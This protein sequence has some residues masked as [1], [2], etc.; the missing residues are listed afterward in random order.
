LK[1]ELDQFTKRA[2]TLIEPPFPSK[3]V[4]QQY[5]VEYIKVH[6][7]E[8]KQHMQNKFLYEEWENKITRLALNFKLQAEEAKHLND[9]DFATW[10]EEAIKLNPCP[11]DPPPEMNLNLDYS[12]NVDLYKRLSI[13]IFSYY[14][15]E[16]RII[17]QANQN[18]VDS[19][20]KS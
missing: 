13:H 5:S 8:Y 3:P 2:R 14:Q 15:W 12:K 18:K 9:S 17:M 16:H 10:K 11:V 19:L 4:D 1:K 7:V 6:T 20:Q